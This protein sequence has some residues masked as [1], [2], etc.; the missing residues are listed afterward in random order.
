MPKN[1]VSSNQVKVTSLVPIKKWIYKQLVKLF[2]DAIKEFLF[3]LSDNIVQDT[4]MSFY[5]VLPAATAVRYKTQLL[6]DMA[7]KGPKRQAHKY[8]KSSSF[9]GTLPFKSRAAG[10]KLGSRPSA[11]N[12]DYGSVENLKFLFEFQIMV[13][14]FYL[15]NYGIDNVESPAWHAFEKATIALHRFWTENFDKYVPANVIVRY[16][17]TGELRG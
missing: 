14:Q 5:S 6:A 9:G 15:R 2:R 7:G 8:Y 4:G 3:V 16:L 10:Y 12:I 11:Y 1:V 13:L 17:W